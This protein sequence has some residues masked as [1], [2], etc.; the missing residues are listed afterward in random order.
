MARD[1]SDWPRCLL[2]H[3]W[4]PGLSAAGERAPWPILWVIL[5]VLGDV[6]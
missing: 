1:R 2:W 6:G 5:S 4:L 3:N